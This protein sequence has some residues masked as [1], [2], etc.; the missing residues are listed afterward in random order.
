MLLKRTALKKILMEYYKNMGNR[1]YLNKI[2]I[3]HN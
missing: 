3:I 1:I 2:S